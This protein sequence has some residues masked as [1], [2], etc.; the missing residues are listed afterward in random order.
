[1]LPQLTH[2]LEA[3]L[4]HGQR[5]EEVPLRRGRRPADHQRAVHTAVGVAAYH[6]NLRTEREADAERRAERAK[7][8]IVLR[9][10]E[11]AL[12]RQRRGRT[13]HV[14]G[15][16]VEDQTLGGRQL[17]KGGG[18]MCLTA[19]AHTKRREPQLRR[20]ERGRLGQQREERAQ[21]LHWLLGAQQLDREAARVERHH[22]RDAR[23]RLEHRARQ[24]SHPAQ[25]A[26]GDHEARQPSRGAAAIHGRCAARG[27]YARLRRVL[28]TRRLRCGGCARV[29]AR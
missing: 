16:P 5:A 18:E 10:E 20:R 4:G 11:V 24:Q 1:M 2:R 17:R 8:E 28:R 23:R 29:C 15:R 19:A 27:T 25:R 22:V 7:A 12:V 21:Q 3:V 6:R 26:A 9:H 14:G 13:A